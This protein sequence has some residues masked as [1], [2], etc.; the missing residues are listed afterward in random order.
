[1]FRKGSCQFFTGLLGALL[2]ILISANCGGGSGSS[3]SGTGQEFLYATSSNHIYSTT[4]DPATGNLAF[5]NS[6]ALPVPNPVILTATVADSKGKFL[7]YFDSPEG[8]IDVFSI[9]PVTGNISPAG[10]SPF[11]AGTATTF[12]LAGAAIDPSGRFFYLASLLVAPPFVGLN[13]FGVNAQSGGLTPIA[14]S[15]FTTANV[16]FAAV[17]HPSGKF[18]YL[19]GSDGTIAAFEIDSITG[20]PTPVSGSPFP[21]PAPAALFFTAIDPSGK[22]LYASIPLKLDSGPPSALVPD[23]RIFAWSIDSTTGSLSPVPGSPFT[24]GSVPEQMVIDP[25][26]KFLYLPNV[27]DHAVSGFSIDQ[28][29]GVLTP[30]SGSPFSIPASLLVIDPSGKYLFAA[31]GKM[32]NGYNINPSTGELTPI[33][34]ELVISF[35]DPIRQLTM[36]KPQ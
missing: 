13:I 11:S 29:S 33:V 25:S 36:V 23:N 28:N 10:G 35:A 22:Y 15:P 17:T 14:G 4:V 20:M 30:V 16:A 9:N 19:S 34:L 6:T 18:V 3:N 31:A 2:L 7:Y 32:I 12:G 5:P 1:M 21:I 27:Q 26:G 24:T 8:K